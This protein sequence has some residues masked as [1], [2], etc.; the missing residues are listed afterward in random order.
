MLFSTSVSKAP[1]LSVQQ[2]V[3]VKGDASV[4]SSGCQEQ[5]WQG[6]AG[7]RGGPGVQLHTCRS[8]H[9]WVGPTRLRTGLSTKFP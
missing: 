1:D 9:A 5:S 8:R 3:G 4:L 2:L 7:G 6:R